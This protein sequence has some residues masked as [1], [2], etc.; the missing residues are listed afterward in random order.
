MPNEEFEKS[1]E[2]RGTYVLGILAILISL[3]TSNV[4]F[5]FNIF[6]RTLDLNFVINLMLLIWFSYAMVIL[7][8][9]SDIF[10]ENINKIII[11]NSRSILSIGFLIIFAFLFVNY[12]NVQPTKTAILFIII[13]GYVEF[14]AIIDMVKKVRTDKIKF[15]YKQLINNIFNFRNLKKINLLLIGYFIFYI[16]VTEEKA[17]YLIYSYLGLIVSLIFYWYFTKGRQQS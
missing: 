14:S 5:A 3:K 9:L 8:A 17:G 7:L 2:M 16:L 1:D 10:V 11:E 6:D 12:A 15:D 4:N 13:L